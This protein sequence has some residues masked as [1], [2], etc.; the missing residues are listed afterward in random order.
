VPSAY[1][2]KPVAS[3]GKVLAPCMQ[4]LLASDIVYV[5]SYYAPAGK[6]LQSD[7]IDVKVPTSDFL[8]DQDVNLV[9]PAGMAS[10]LQR[11]KPG[12]ATHGL[13]GLRLDTVVARAGDG[14][15]K[16]LQVGTVN[17]VKITG[18]TFLVT[19]TNGG[20]FTEF[21]VGVKVTIG[22]GDT[23]IVKTAT[24]DQIGKGQQQTVEI[25]NFQNDNP[26]FGKQ[27][28]MTVTVEPVPGERT[29]SNNTQTYQITFSL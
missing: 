20:D 12:S 24:I 6:A 18:L 2:A 4:R 23:K 11:W 25:S 13:H 5:D 19:A 8:S 10:V 7:N 17:Q 21:N 16:T 26:Q 22:S 14:T 28:P 27:L 29:A 3:G 15:T 1:K 9:T